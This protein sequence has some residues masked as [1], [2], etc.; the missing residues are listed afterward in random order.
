MFVFHILSSQVFGAV[1]VCVKISALPVT[2][3]FFCSQLF[4]GG[5]FLHWFTIHG[6]AGIGVACAI[7]YY[8]GFLCLEFHF[9]CGSSFN[10]VVGQV[11]LPAIRSI[12]SAKH[13]S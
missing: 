2:T 1:A 5:H 13:R 3:F 6:E 4:E 9:I 10:E 7:Q 8:F 12:L 11:L